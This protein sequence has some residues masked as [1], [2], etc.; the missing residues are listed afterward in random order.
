MPPVANVATNSL[1]LAGSSTYSQWLPFSKLTCTPIKG[2]LSCSYQLGTARHGGKDGG[3]EEGGR[4]GGRM[5]GW[6]SQ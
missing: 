6:V 1:N 3:R 4:V 2:A 5:G